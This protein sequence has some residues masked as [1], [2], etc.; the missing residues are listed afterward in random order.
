MERNPNV[1]LYQLYIEAILS[2]DFFV[3]NNENRSI[4]TKN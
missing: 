4:K 1:T 3:S 2:G